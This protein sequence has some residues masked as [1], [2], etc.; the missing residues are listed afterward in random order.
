MAE[1]RS[2]RRWI[3]QLSQ[4]K[5]RRA[6]SKKQKGLMLRAEVL[7]PRI[8]PTAD[9]WTGAVNNLWSVD[10]NWLDGTKPTTGEDL[11]FPSTATNHTSVY[12]PALGVTDFGSITIQDS[13]Y[14]LASSTASFINLSSSLSTTYGSGISHYLI[15][16]NLN[17]GNV[18]VGA[19]GDLVVEGSINGSAGLAVAGGGTLE[20]ASTST[21]A[22]TGPTEVMNGTTLVLNKTGVTAISDD[23]MV[24]AGGT[25]Q[26]LQADQIADT[27]NVTLDTGA[28]LL[29][30][31]LNETIHSL[32]LTGA[33]IGTGVGILT[34]TGDLTANTSVTQST[35][36]G[37][38]ALAGGG[39]HLFN[40]AN[41]APTA[42]PDLDISAVVSGADGIAKTGAGVLKLGG[43]NTYTGTTD[44]QAGTVAIDNASA[45][46]TTAGGTTIASG[47]ELDL[48]SDLNL[49]EPLSL[50]G[51]GIN[52]SPIGLG[53][54]IY[55]LSGNLT[56]TG[57]TTLSTAAAT[58]LT[59]SGVIDDGTNSY[60]LTKAGL[61]T[62]TLS[63][64]NTYD[65]GT[66]VAAGTLQTNNSAAL[67]TGDVMAPVGTNLT[68]LNTGTMANNLVIGG[69][70]LTV[71]N[72][73][74]VMLTG[75][76]TLS[77]DATINPLNNSQIDFAGT[78]SGS[79]ALDIASGT[80]LN[81]G[82]VTFSGNA[83]N[84]YT[85]AT[86]LHTGTLTLSKSG[87][88]IA[89]PGDLNL[90]DG[91]AGF[92]TT[93]TETAGDQIADTSN[94]SLTAGSTLDLNGFDDT[95]AGLT[96]TGSTVQ[97]GAG[98]LTLTGNLTTLDALIGASSISGNLSLPAS[99]T[100]A[101]ADGAEA[102]D[103]DIDGVISGAATSLTKAGAGTLQLSGA[104]ANTF[105]GMTTVGAGSLWLNKAPGQHAIAGD[106]TL[107]DLT[108]V[109]LQGSDQIGDPSLVSV[110]DGAS[111]S[112]ND[113]DETIGGLSLT[114]GN[115]S[116]GAGTLTLN[117]D[118]TSNAASSPS[119]I[120]GNLDLGGATRTFNVSDDPFADPDLIITANISG[121]GAGIIKDGADSRL[122]LS[123]NNTYDGATTINAGILSVS[124]A[125]ALGATSA[126]TTV[127]SGAVLQIEAVSGLNLAPE[128]ITLNGTG[129]GG[130]GALSS[131]IG[132]NSMVGPITFGTDTSIWVSASST[133]TVYGQFTDG[134]NTLGFTKTGGGVLALTNANP[135]HGTTE[136][137]EGVI[138]ASNGG[139][140]GTGAVV[141]DDGAALE[142]SGDIALVNSAFTVSGSG[143]NGTGALH[144]TSGDNTLTS[145]V[146]LG[147]DPT[148][149]GVDAGSSL[150]IATT[151]IS[152]TTNDLTKVGLGTLN[153]EA[154]AISWT[155]N[156]NANEGR[157]NVDNA[158]VFSVATVNDGG[159]L[160]GTGFVGVTTSNSG[161]T[162]AP[163]LAGGTGVLHTAALNMDPG[164]T[165]SV[166]V[167]GTTPGSQ[168]D[169][170]AVTGIVTIVS[171]AN[172]AVNLG[173]IPAIGD[174]FTIINNDTIVDPVVGAFAGLPEG[175]TFNVGNVEFQISYAGG[176]GN[177]VT[178]NVIGVTYTWTGLGGDNNWSTG[179]NW[180][181]GQ[182]PTAGSDLVFPFGGAQGLNNNDLTSGMSF[183]S[184]TVSGSGYDLNG[185]DINLTDGFN[186]GATGSVNMNINV[187]LAATQNFDVATGGM[188]SYYGFISGTGYGVTKTGGGTLAFNN[189]YIDNSYTGTTT[190]LDGTLLLNS[191][192]V[193]VP[194]DLVVGDGMGTG[195][196]VQYNT[197]NEIADS[198]TVTL[199]E[200]A[201]LD[202]NG[203]SDQFSNL[204]MQGATITVNGGTISVLTSI[205]VNA[206]INNIVST[207]SG[208]GS[209]DLASDNVIFAIADDTDTPVD[210]SVSA[211]V[212]DGGV[213]K[214]GAGVAAFS[215]TNT[216]D[217]GTTV[218][219]GALQIQ[220]NGGLGDTLNPVVVSN[221]ASVFFD[222]VG[223]SIPQSFQINGSGVG[224]IGALA[225]IA[226]DATLSGAVNLY[227][228]SSVGAANGATLTLNGAIDDVALP[229]DLQI[230]N[231]ATGRTVLGGTNTNFNSNINVVSGY[232]TLTNSSALGNPTDSTSTTLADGSTLELTGSITIPATK[233]I[234]VQLNGVSA[235]S[236]KIVNLSGDNTV[237]G[238]ITFQGHTE[239][240]TVGGTSLI[241]NGAIGED[242]SG[243]R[244]IS[245]GAGTLVLNG[246]NSY[247]G[248]TFV[249]DG[250]LVVNGSIAASS[251]AQVYG[252][253]L[254][255][256]GTTPGVTVHS[257]GAIAPG[258]SPGILNTGDVSF[259]SGS[260]YDVELDG[261]T[262][263]SQY[264][265]LNVIGAV[266]LGSSTLN[267]S[268]GYG[269]LVGDTYTIV[270][271][272]GA[273]AITGTFNGLAEGSTITIG[274]AT[275]QISYIGGDGNDVTLTVT[276]TT[277]TWSGAVDIYWSN[278][279]NWVEGFAPTAGADLIFPINPTHAESLNDLA[280]GIP[281]HSITIAGSGY[282]IYGNPIALTDG[283]N[284]TLT[285]GSSSFGVD[286]QLLQSETITVAA[287]GTLDIPSVIS[288]ILPLFGVTKDGAGILR[289]LGSSANA[290]YG[291]TT[292]NAGTLVL[293]K[294]GVESV[295]GTLNIG[296]GTT[297]ATVELDSSNQ[298][299]DGSIVTV[300]EGSS[301]N[302][303]VNQELI[304][305]LTLEGASV[306][307][308]T[309][310]VLS[311]FS[312][313]VSVVP[314][315]DVTST[316]NGD[317]ELE[318]FN[319]G[320]NFT[321]SHDVNL[322][323]DLSIGAM[324]GGTGGFFTTGGGVLALSGANTYAGLTSLS[325][326][327]LLVENDSA[328]GATIAGTSVS[329]GTSVV[330]LGVG[331]N[332][333]EP[334]TIEGS[335]QAV[336]GVL[337]TASGDATLTG[338]ITLTGNAELGASNGTTLTLNGVIDDGAN[339]YNL[340][341]S[342]GNSGHT[343]L[344]GNNTY[345][346][347][348]TVTN[349]YLHLTSSNALGD[350]ATASFVDLNDNAT[351]ELSGDISLP[352]TKTLIFEGGGG[353]GGL[354]PK[355]INLAG[356]NSAAGAIQLSANS[357]F[358][359]ASGT[360]LVLNGPIS[361]GGDVFGIT[362]SG[363]GKLV[364]NGLSSYTGVTTVS[365]GIFEV[366][367]DISSSSAI[368]V[369]ADAMLKGS[370]VLPDMTVGLGGTVAPG[371]SPGILTTGDIDL[372]AGSTYFAELDGTTV[373]TQYDQ[374]NVIGTVNLS[375]PTLTLSLGF[376]PAGGETF[377]IL[378]NDGSDP[379]TGTFAGLPEGAV[380]NAGGY[381]FQISYVGGDG[382]DVVLTALSLTT[383]ELSANHSTITY[384]D[385]LTFTAL[386]TANSGT[387]TG[388]VAF[389]NGAALPGNLLGT[390]T[391]NS[392]GIATFT[393]TSLSVTG[394]PYSV[395]AVYA[396]AG[397]FVGSTSSAFDVTVNQALLTVTADDLSRIYGD[398]NPTLTATFTGFVNGETLATSD[399]T[400][401]ADLSTL[402][403]PNSPING[404]P[405]AITASIGTLMS[406]NYAFTFVDGNL[407]VTPAT[408]TVS[409]DNQSREYGDANPTLTASFSGFK[410]GQTLATSDVTGSADLSTLADPNSPVSGSPYT[411]TAAIGS[412]ASSNYIFSFVDGN[413]DVT[414]ATLTVTADDLSKIYGEINPALTATFTGFKNGQTLATSDVT[415][416]PGL[417]TS[418]TASSH[419]TGSPYAITAAIG[420]LQS[421][422]YAFTLVD[423]NLSVTPALLT[424]T[425]NDQSKVYGEPV[426]TL[427]ASYNGFVNGDTPQSLTI[428]PT[429]STTATQF[430]PVSGSPY[431]ITASGALDSDYAI[432]Y[433]AGVLNIAQAGTTTTLN[434]STNPTMYGQSVTF[435]A[436]VATVSP[437]SGT[438]DGSVE[439]F[440]GATSLGSVLLSGGTASI[441]T[442]S[443][444]VGSHTITAVYTPLLGGDFSG[445]AT[446]QA[447]SQQV[448]PAP[449]AIVFQ[450]P[451]SPTSA[452]GVPVDF[453]VTVDTLPPGVG[454]ATGTVQF[455][456]GAT[457]L[458]APLPLSGGS[459]GFSIANL[460]VGTHSIVAKYD[461]ADGSF[462][463][464]T[465]SDVIE[466]TAAATTVTVSSNHPT[467]VVGESVTFTATV[468]RLVA[469]LGVPSGTVTFY[470]GATILG[471]VS[472]VAGQASLTTSFGSVG[473]DSITAV[474]S[475][476]TNFDPSTS[477]IYL[478][479][480]VASSSTTTVVQSVG[481][482]V[483][484]QPVTFAA[485]VVPVSP[486]MG[487]PTGTVVFKDGSTV[488]GTASLINGVASFTTGSLAVGM[489]AITATYNGTADF[490]PSTSAVLNT[491][492]A[493]ANSTTTLTAPGS[494]I[495]SQPIVLSAHV[496]TSAPGVASPVG[497]VRFFD[498][499]TLIGSANL[500][501][502]VA[503]LVVSTLAP[504]V[505]SLTAMYLGDGELNASQ[506]A[507][508][509]INVDPASTATQLVGP[510]GPLAVGTYA[511]FHATVGSVSPASGVPNGFI[512]FQVNG[513]VMA[514][515][516][517]VNG[518]ATFTLTPSYPGSMQTVTAVFVGNAGY[519]TSTSQSLSYNV[520]Q[521]ETSL[522]L[523]TILNPR[524]NGLTL[525]GTVGT[526][527]VGIAPTGTLTF[528]R[529]SR[530]V[531]SVG[532]AFRTVSLTGNQ[533][534]VFTR[535]LAAL[536]RHFFVRYNGD[537]NFLPSQ[538]QTI[539]VTRST[540]ATPRGP[541][542]AF[543]AV[544]PAAVHGFGFKPLHRGR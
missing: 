21:N 461:S 429:L 322:N 116:T 205:T 400:G 475:G 378:N 117:G 106:L 52:G 353:D 150:T 450:Q 233:T 458:T 381:G 203:Q 38:L 90:G 98:T 299:W 289:F 193:V 197:S 54:G 532:R 296:D 181:T 465:A 224:G 528:Y 19:G 302:V 253:V 417:L 162:I 502:G 55:T 479:M 474:Y 468:D 83:S 473:N 482:P 365:A 342:N 183:H 238:P 246:T 35:V 399:V 453:L 232:L 352:A 56:L 463:D 441:T 442:A 25:V 363:D 53:A 498:G 147:T 467:A 501:G 369:A 45:L 377:T 272:D 326:I 154:P 66:T 345:H 418:A 178:L 215:G 477:P 500:S 211:V 173:F 358:Q 9:V 130:L 544:R 489:H 328:L 346:G 526:P 24:D 368:N 340:M 60:A 454:I 446:T 503:Q 268:L 182:A 411:I 443:F 271:N 408:L 362:K 519:R 436:Q 523:S 310:G 250:R 231:G 136:I 334:F 512:N 180:D 292:V 74:S 444:G 108:T 312:Q 62:A 229:F 149:I 483:A 537:A 354:A 170:L 317:G 490:D 371:N 124:S 274:P 73:G 424:I 158:H 222:G 84:T 435:T 138:Q 26:L 102:V 524:G 494:S 278:P 324:I 445:S 164:S 388:V 309:G 386:V 31:G 466:V 331:L 70:A 389:Y 370:G 486:G 460:S 286:V 206:S 527:A 306:Q 471:T 304:S 316:I 264:D 311:I 230:S 204:V 112:L 4:S 270:N 59:V 318:L 76:V 534:S 192:H 391:L 476:S 379:V 103:L 407:N 351:L 535:K 470:N 447:L 5:G 202:F 95:I 185:N 367:G 273:D 85:G 17:N 510:I 251:D 361:D 118:V 387:P 110:G 36:S 415:G 143:I 156:L 134:G 176:D 283:I 225:T 120:S 332:V 398:A 406:G 243:R 7:E 507:A 428:P 148:V 339:V 432:Q 258:N 422:N 355:L 430:S 330:F 508:S 493:K 80:H 160:G 390:G 105:T 520:I 505:H 239:I 397:L 190:V 392:L 177:D 541:G 499:T 93:V 260:S 335:G 320:V 16:T 91:P 237:N 294:S 198:A 111:F 34:L 521:A 48:L 319:P 79:F 344:G 380:F 357:E 234:I 175:S 347:N 533:A 208:P 279:A 491:N 394:S 61:G 174:S 77:S 146:T 227:S 301:F 71:D 262:V 464:T 207:I 166:D 132:S 13:G 293:A 403:D 104:S 396:G 366:N 402:A 67:G 107:G 348:T 315:N 412:L 419:V 287:G 255:G 488:L 252:G 539:N 12:D 127:I 43:S 281:F 144:S 472:L 235:I 497:V 115:V 64:T 298:I 10:G 376:S 169:Q 404:S 349:G 42:T 269:P 492:V 39:T 2:D 401:S 97:T 46:G 196:V 257:G 86:T 92:P 135:Y 96:L 49:A 457:S 516:P 247:S 51:T 152:G 308:D 99:A 385:Q 525:V 75:D 540:F 153:L 364:L 221:G 333:A 267:V 359:T 219:A 300:K 485:T 393:T 72:S 69:N 481:A 325:D 416:T 125:T 517:V 263:G 223:L 451:V 179:A 383:T 161:G 195:E 536:G 282:D 305:V 47:A 32:S 249:L 114:A 455:F 504:G 228:A 452:F 448:N 413:L 191:D 58:F 341:V 478:Q 122:S 14:N 200:G 184:I 189:N 113:F 462:A 410:N 518:G 131:S 128:P 434:S 395:I 266:D 168:Y 89:I 212:E 121:T 163:G 343:I 515:V 30:G 350:S 338:A 327:V 409:A 374:L 275:L 295:G 423:G 437:G 509:T 420:T 480:V 496:L 307:I 187:T 165:F 265:Q 41:P 8:T 3:E 514:T 20:L 382:N 123:G 241:L 495:N 78:I 6:R 303:G 15:N 100:I 209:L 129:F 244:L 157:L 155:G 427:T 119:T 167:N 57:D 360:T 23:L 438:P 421:G 82:G 94:V 245:D 194:G 337:S 220:S 172:L 101:V 210:F 284:A 28:S 40:A 321:I 199:N 171:G 186:V 384:G 137:S 431:T 531:M 201:T 18:S 336:I 37:N 290:Y 285:S 513:V 50:A 280:P 226:G 242:L 256:S 405:Y 159:T 469:G 440:D 538:S 109:V 254:G 81:P 530:P 240:S 65:G 11:I 373:G 329:S 291:S 314:T 277:Y 145:G 459:T 543:H 68:I 63:G 216:Y 139:S 313:V 288:S 214:T 261:A 88:A 218:S 323:V 213:T 425:A 151:G 44:I 29:L 217:F 27:A 1:S 126:G 356:D 297:A 133:L 22:Y 449:T 542:L 511:T 236:P 87:G 276:A 248:T 33:S 140:M 439:F 142:L 372:Q 426:P 456:D 522:T 487:V 433:V 259:N 506:S 188:L 529:T 141:V 484:G 375:D 414:K